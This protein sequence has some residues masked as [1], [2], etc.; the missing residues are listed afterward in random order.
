MRA[1]FLRYGF[2]WAAVSLCS[3]GFVF[4]GAGCR[5]RNDLAEKSGGAGS[6]KGPVPQVRATP[7]L[8]WDQ[9]LLRSSGWLGGDGLY[10]M[11]LNGVRN[12]RKSG[13]TDTFLWFSD[14]IIGTIKEDSLQAGWAMV[15]NS[16]GYVRGSTPD[17]NNM[18]FY[19]GKDEQ[20]NPADLFVP[21]TPHAQPGDYYWLG[22]AFFNH[23]KD[24]TLYLFAYRIKKLPGGVY[25]FEDVGVS[26]IVLPKGSRPP[27]RNHR[28]LDTPLFLKDSQGK[29]KV[30]FGVA[31]LAN[32]VGAGAPRP[33]GYVYVYGVRGIG[34]ELLVARVKEEAFED[35]SQWRYW[36]GTTWSE[37]IHKSGALTSRVSNEMSVSF[38]DDGRVMATYQLDTDAPTVM[39]QAGQTPTGPFQPAKRIFET[40]EIYDDLDFYTYNAKAHPH[41]SGPGE[42]LISYNVNSFD[43][44]KDI[45]VHPNHYRSR[46]IRVKL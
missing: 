31:V 24:S 18:A 34:K 43:F 10:S 6:A 30:V 17:P 7:A 19:W 38:M 9:V 2:K 33:D 28:Q 27:F 39:I 20:G 1:N 42:L 21:R 4:L 35:F 13:N 25:P 45:L 3:F 5:G 15:H 12:Q 29:G 41:L 14:S 16:V 44:F 32:T 22:D 37:D 23:R 8:E 11:P 40:P 26:L 36:D 46:F